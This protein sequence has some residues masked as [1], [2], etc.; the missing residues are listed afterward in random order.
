MANPKINA[1]IYTSRAT[2]LLEVLTKGPASRFQLVPA[3]AKN[4]SELYVLMQELRKNGVNI[5][6]TDAGGNPT[7]AIIKKKA[8]TKRALPRLRHPGEVL[9]EAETVLKTI[10]DHF[11][12]AR[13]KTAADKLAHAVYHTAQAMRQIAIGQAPPEV[14]NGDCCDTEGV[15]VEYDQLIPLLTFL[16]E[17]SGLVI[18]TIRDVS[19]PGVTS[20][21]QRYIVWLK[22]GR[23]CIVRFLDFL[24]KE[25]E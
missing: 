20:W 7:W 22:D 4:H 9:D 14:E 8:P 1:G 17:R 24:D 11:K 6:R 3:V 10:K 5:E 21:R 2:K 15:L 19:T 25:A 23:D 16:G 18:H 13:G 12:T